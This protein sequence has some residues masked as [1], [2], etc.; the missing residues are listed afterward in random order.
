MDNELYAS[1]GRS[2]RRDRL[3]GKLFKGKERK[4]QEQNE[5]RAS[6]DAFLHNSADNLTVTHAPPPPPPSSIPKLSKLDTTVSRFPQALGVNQQAQQ[7]RPLALSRPDI[8]TPRPSP[9]P[10][11]KGLL[12]RFADTYP[13]V[14]GEGGDETDVPTVEISKRKKSRPPK[15]P[16][17]PTPP[18]HRSPLPSPSPEPAHAPAP[19]ARSAPSG[20][21]D[22]FQPKPL[23]RTQTG[24]SSIYAPE[25]DESARAHEQPPP[26]PPPRVQP[27]VEA[28]QQDI[29][30][31]PP[32]NTLRPG[33]ANSARYLDTTGR[34]DE[35]RRSFIEVQRAHMRQD[36]GQAL[37]R[38]SRT[39][40]AADQDWE[41]SDKVPPSSVNSSPEQ[42]RQQLASSETDPPNPS[43]SYSP[44]DSIYSSESDSSN[45][46]QRME[47]NRQA[48]VLSQHAP[49][50][51][52]SREPSAVSQNELPQLRTPLRQASFKLH[53][54]VVAAADD[55]LQTFVARTKHLCELFR[56]HAET[57]KPLSNCAL[58]DCARAGV[59][60][61]L[62]GRMGLETTIREKT[63]TPQHQMQ[64]EI[65]RQQAYTNLAKGYWLCAE[66]VP[67]IAKVQGTSPDDEVAE[68]TEALV[69]ALTKLSMSMKR[70][71]LLPPEEAF[72]P[73]TIDKSIWVEYPPLSQD[74]VALLSGNWGSGLSAMQHPLSTLHLL[75]AFPVSDSADNFSYGRVAADIYLMEQGRESQRLHLPSMVSMVRP[76]KHTG[77]VFVLANQNGTLQLAIQ[78]NKNAGPVWDDIRWRSDTCAL[79][80]KLPRGFMLV[81]QLTQ[82]D[83]R[84]LWNMY[85]FGAKVKATLYPKSDEVIVFRNTLKSFQYVDADPNSRI[86]P[87]EAVP[88]CEVALFE[89]IFKESGPQGIRNWH[90]GFRV[91]VVTGTQTRTLSG[92]QH[93][94]SP[95]MPV[96]FGFFR[97]EGESPALSLRFENGRQ[98]GRMNLTFNEDKERIKFHS[99]LTGTALDHDEQIYADVALKS[100]T[101]SQSL[102]EPLGMS[103]FSRMP[104]K[105]A[106][107][108]NEELGPSGEQPPTVLADKLKMILEYQNG[109]IADR[110]NIGPGE[111]RLRLEVTNAKM[112]RI[113]RQPQADM[114]MAVSEAQVP[115]E[116]PRNFADA[117]QLVKMS[118]S[119]RS[120]EF[121]SLKDLHNFQA[122]LT[123]YEVIFDALAATFAIARR[124]MVVPIHK[125]WEASYT[126]IQLVKQDDKLQ[127]LAFFE[128]FHH[129][130]CMGFVLKGTDVYETFNRSNK[131]GLRFIDAK[132]PLPRLPV[133]K[134]GDYDD[135]AFVS[136]DLPDLPGEHDDISITFENETGEFAYV[137]KGSSQGY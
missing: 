24:Y 101:L 15:A 23:A 77:L 85:D 8:N 119:I 99:L 82:Q 39:V 61:F 111:L 59:W 51:L 121:G 117:L 81:V 16:V 41:D 4:V 62:K 14:I 55:A 130:H 136:L 113:M 35:A 114:T 94:Y 5:S 40:S 68:V 36:E 71:G 64:N 80:I 17:A 31:S 83:F 98:R 50:R 127:L 88:H 57:V 11:K 47:P 73:Q 56:L 116:L 6:L 123:G 33:R 89:R 69:S 49:P 66:A 70:N 128:D 125:K 120:L 58:K 46:R 122:A 135:M 65:D 9:R 91:A 29:G 115:K 97:V 48:S 134:D 54:V 133:D 7:N 13:E 63:K 52:S 19:V 3:M 44:A 79:D 90:R 112:L 96:Q 60:W 1:E 72:L 75:D 100:V 38:A 22:D 92:V 131:S 20:P 18:P 126:R 137:H 106:K 10:N 45:A 84:S 105:A 110:I 108:V 26:I 25:A 76:K 30:G 132:F 2:S 32:A 86:F 67:E 109:T 118:P 21:F 42:S 104:W 124:R 43:I 93:N 95:S 37:A 12:V 103:P 28:D 87:K 107:V 74:L 27:P 53:D 34:N 78:E 129:G 102:R